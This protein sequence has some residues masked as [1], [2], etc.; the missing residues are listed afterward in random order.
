M[1]EELHNIPEVLSPMRIDVLPCLLNLSVHKSNR[2]RLA[3]MVND[4]HCR[5]RADA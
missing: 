5:N 2:V 1:V 3:S 4:F